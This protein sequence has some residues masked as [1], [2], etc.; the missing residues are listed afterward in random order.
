VSPWKREARPPFPIRCRGVPLDGA[1]YHGP[2]QER[3][4]SMAGARNDG[5][6]T[7]SKGG[8]A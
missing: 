1:S 5:A 3:W 4:L 8:E 7:V 6:R 2:L